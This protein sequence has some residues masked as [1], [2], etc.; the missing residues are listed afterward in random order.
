MGSSAPSGNPPATFGDA[1]RQL[2]EGNARY[3]NNRA[4]RPRQRPTDAPQHP[5]AVILS[6]SD[7]RVPPEIAFDMGVGD[8]FVIRAA[9]NTYDRLALQSIEYAV[10]H[11]GAKL[12]VVM[13]H[14]RCGAVTAALGSYPDPHAGPML[15]NIYPAVRAAEHMPGDRVSNTVGEN[16]ILVARR[17]AEEPELAERVKRGEL[18][19][20]AARY[21]LAT[22]TVHVLTPQ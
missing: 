16:A 7:S 8:L 19:I 10:E 17:L 15:V 12:I 4:L 9:G 6:C 13:G 1:L 14:E 5:I 18:R 21:D 22:G 3:V 20:A 2:L 11:L